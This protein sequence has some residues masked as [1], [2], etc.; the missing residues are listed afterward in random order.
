VQYGTKLLW[1]KTHEL[2]LDL[3]T[4]YLWTCFNYFNI[5]DKSK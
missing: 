4:I 2:M 1:C 3:Q 5:K